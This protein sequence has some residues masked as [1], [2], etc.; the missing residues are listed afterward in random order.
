MWDN[1][2]F[3]EL[4]SEFYEHKKK[5]WGFVGRYGKFKLIFWGI[6]C[7]ILILPYIVLFLTKKTYEYVD[8]IDNLQEPIQTAA[9]WWTTMYIH[10]VDVKID[11]LAS[12]D[13]RWKVISIRDYAWTDIEKWLGPRD[14][15]LWW[16][17]MSKQEI[18]DKFKW[19]DL[20]NRFIY[21]YVPYWNEDRFDQ[22]FDGD[23]KHNNLWTAITQFSNNHLIPA[24][25]K[26]RTLVKKIKEWDVV[27]LKWYLVYAYWETNKWKY[28]RWPSSL[29]RDDWDAHSCEIIYVTDVVWLKEK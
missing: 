15:V 6:L 12:Y 18:I 11:F 25:K 9:S 22:E 24:N 19:N 16:W 13:I 29:V 28:W 14:F 17:K 20:R 26:I 10:W 3:E 8:D 2:V 5:E 1:K 23:I 27:R 7:L 21:I 4:S